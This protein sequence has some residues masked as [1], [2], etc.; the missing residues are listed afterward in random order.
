MA[1]EIQPIES[2]ERLDVGPFPG[3]KVHFNTEIITLC[4]T[5]ESFTITNEEVTSYKKRKIYLMLLFF[6]QCPLSKAFASCNYFI[7]W[8]SLANK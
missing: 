2:V 6:R 8:A 4:C 5:E 7:P 3:G 1:L